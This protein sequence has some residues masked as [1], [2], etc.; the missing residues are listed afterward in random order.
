MHEL[1][2]EIDDSGYEEMPKEIYARWLR[3][4]ERF[5]KEEAEHPL[6]IVRKTVK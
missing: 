5:K 6:P 1:Y 2:R 3:Y 4:M